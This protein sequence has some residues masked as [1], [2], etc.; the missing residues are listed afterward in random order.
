MPKIV[1]KRGRLDS[2]V[3]DIEIDLSELDSE[4][5]AATPDDDQDSQPVF[6]FYKE[7]WVMQFRF[8]E[9]MLKL[10]AIAIFCAHEQRWRVYRDGVELASATELALQSDFNGVVRLISDT[11]GHTNGG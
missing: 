8:A 1:S 10:G 4:H 2:D 7:D 11:I 6:E 9:E 3:V 5:L